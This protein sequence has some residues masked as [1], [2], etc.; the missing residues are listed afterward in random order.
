MRSIILLLNSSNSSAG[1]QYS[2]QDYD[3]SYLTISHAYL[4]NV[5]LHRVNF[6]YADLTHSVFDDTVSSIQTLAFHPQ[7]TLLASGNSRGEVNLWELETRQSPTTLGK[8]SGK[9][10]SV[11]FS[12]DGNTL[13]S[14]GEDGRLKFWDIKT[15]KFIRVLQEYNSEIYALAWS[16]HNKTITSS[17]NNNDTV[18][19]LA[20]SP[21]EPILVSGSKDCTI[22]FWNI[23]TGQ[24]LKTI[25]EQAAVI[26]VVFS[27]DGKTV[28]SG[29]QDGQ[30]KLWDVETGECLQTLKS[31]GLY[32]E[33]NITGVKGL[34]DEQ[35]VKLKALGAVE[36]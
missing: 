29:S 24:C 8:H 14:G 7:K 36:N 15:N 10:L 28:A 32:E 1:T 33:M 26:S 4:K 16:P 19:S 18:N 6:A 12:P 2:L 9:V 5:D 3:F 27:P 35:I 30:I 21:D 20:F 23:Y 31:I 11:A 22:K 25:S 13:A 17:I 34:T